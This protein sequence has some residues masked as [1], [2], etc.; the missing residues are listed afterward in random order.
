MVLREAGAIYSSLIKILIPAII[1]V[2]VLQ[3]T[4][5]VALVGDLMTPLMN[6]IGLPSVL[7]IVWFLMAFY[8]HVLRGRFSRKLYPCR[9]LFC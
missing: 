3:A 7:S 1:I 4:G 9:G 5:V 8:V 6:L 2:T